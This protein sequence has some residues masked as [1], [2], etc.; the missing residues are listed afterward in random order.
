MLLAAKTRRVSKHAPVR[1]GVL[2]ALMAGQTIDKIGKTSKLTRARIER[3]L[4]SELKALSIRPAQDYAKLQIRRLEAVVDRVTVKANKGDL[5]AIDRL[6]RILDRLDRYHGFAKQ[7]MRPPKPDE[8]DDLAFDKKLADLM[9]RA[10][11]AK[12]RE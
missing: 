3:I 9:D 12:G 2:N 8:R 1:P 4:R 6:M 10:E 5:A 7:S 11:R